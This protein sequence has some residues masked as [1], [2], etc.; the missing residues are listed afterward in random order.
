MTGYY[1]RLIAIGILITAFSWTIVAQETQIVG[2]FIYRPALDDFDDTDRSLIATSGE[3]G[4]L[5][6]W[7]CLSDGLNVVLDVETYYGGD[8]DDDIQVRY[9][10]DQ[11]EASGYEYWRLFPAQNEISYQRMNQ[12]PG[13]TAQARL[14]DSVVV[15]AV[16]PLDDESNRFTFELD[17]FSEA[18][19]L[20]PCADTR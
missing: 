10:F 7:R 4:G 15:E 20:L 2:D 12:V 8:D 9:R 18:L 17:G 6:A 16:D 3:D 1:A 11:N 5:L 14:A 13:F 19:N